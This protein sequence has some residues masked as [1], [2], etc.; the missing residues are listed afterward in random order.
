MFDALIPI[1][2]A[3]RCFHSLSEQKN[4]FRVNTL[5]NSV[6][7][8]LSSSS[9]Q[10][11]KT[12]L[13]FAFSSPN[14]IGRTVENFL[15]YIHIQS[16]SSMLPALALSPHKNDIVL[17]A[18]ASPG[19][20][21]TQMAAIMGNDGAIVA[22]DRKSRHPPLLANISRLGVLNTVV[23]SYDAKK[24][25][26]ENYFTKALLDAPCTALGAWQSAWK[27]FKPDIAKSMARVQK[28]ML[29]SAFD[30]LKPGG[31]LV[32]STCTYTK[33]EN[34]EVI[35]FLLERRENA[36]L[37]TINIPY[38]IP[39]ET[40]LSEFGDEFRKVWRVYPWHLKSEGFFIAKVRRDE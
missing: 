27:R 5:K 14:P 18:C 13:P 19:S 12:P 7:E 2:D 6:Q 34:E 30:S 20:K 22:N 24:S 9:I 25:I 17:D 16:L 1:S 23:V 33:E 3:D 37:E 4:Y 35:R 39:H 38:E 26:K 29:L 10:V 8:F 11:E 40:G 21:T 32:Y 15:G 28:A 36:R 31:V